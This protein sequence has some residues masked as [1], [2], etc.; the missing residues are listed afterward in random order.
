MDKPRVTALNKID[1]SL[2]GDREWDEESAL[3]YFS[4][5]PQD[6]NTALISATKKWGLVKL[7]ELINHN[8]RQ[9]IP[10]IPHL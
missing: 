9:T 8:L 10:A 6:E 7:R 3:S 2:S 4:D 1:L 5:Q